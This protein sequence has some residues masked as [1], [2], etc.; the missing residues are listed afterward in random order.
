MEAPLPL[1]SVGNITAGGSGKTPFVIWLAHALKKRGY[2]PVILC[3]GDG[4]SSSTPTILDNQSDPVLVG[5]EARLLFDTS[6]CPVIAAKDRVAACQ[7]AERLGNIIIL[8]DGFQYRHLGRV[9]DIALIPATG[10][11]NGHLI[12]AGPLRE[13]P[14][15]LERA[16]IIVR[17]GSRKELEQ[18]LPLSVNREWQWQSITG[19][20]VDL[21]G[22]GKELPSVLHAVTA[23]ARPYRF[24]DS[25]VASG[26][27]L[28]GTT[29]FPDHH[30]FTHKEVNGFL[31]H[32]DV[33]VTGKDAVK[34]KPLWPRERPLWMLELEGD[35][36]N[37]LLEAICSKLPAQK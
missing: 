13:S 3:R 32:P 27:K 29:S 25:V 21:M 9:C 20:L 34:L 16:D 35:G 23:I 28:T 1:I 37:G 6:G 24:F 2:S 10:I 22:S 33:V 36:E 31:H 15:A 19:G 14:E 4:G 17:T 8:D 18:S 26:F 5:D 30:H 12:P 7:L 11:G